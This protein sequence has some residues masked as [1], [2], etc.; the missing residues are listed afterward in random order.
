MSTRKPFI[1]GIGGAHSS[2]GKTSLAASV[3]RHLKSRKSVSPFGKEPRLGAIKYTRTPLYASLVDDASLI[4]LESKDTARLSAAGADRV[5][6]I[7]S[8]RTDLEEIVPVALSRLADLDIIVIEGNSAIEFAK[9]H[10]VIFIIGQ[11]KKSIKPSAKILSS[12]AD[13]LIVPKAAWAVSLVSMTSAKIYALKTYPY[14]FDDEA[15]KVIIS[16]MEEIVKKKEIE[17]MLK[18]RAVDARLTCTA[19][20]MIAEELNVPYGEVGKTAN[21]LKIK[22]KNCELGCF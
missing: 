14:V 5:L 1:I 17:R 4:G 21:E 3:I 19:A 7:K 12:Q 10:I 9:P 22:I 20:R 18:E 13:I 6:W 15:T 8:P 11:T 2:V 16:F